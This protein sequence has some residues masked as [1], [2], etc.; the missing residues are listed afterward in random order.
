EMV[1]LIRRSQNLYDPV[2]PPERKEGQFVNYAMQKVNQFNRK[3]ADEEY[4]L[5]MVPMDVRPVPRRKITPTDLYDL[6]QNSIAELQQMKYRLGLERTF[7]MPEPE[8]GRTIDDVVYNIELALRLL[9]DF[10]RQKRIQFDQQGLKKR[11]EQV[12]A[13]VNHIIQELVH[14]QRRKG[15]PP[16]AHQQ[17]VRTVERLEPRHTYYRSIEVLRQISRVRQQH[18]LGELT[19]PD[20]PN[21]TITP[22]EVYEM[23]LRIDRELEL[24]YQRGGA[25]LNDFGISHAENLNPDFSTPRT[26]SDVYQH[27]GQVA[28]RLTQLAGGEAESDIVQSNHRVRQLLAELLL[29]AD[30]RGVVVDPV[31]C[32][33]EGE[34]VA[35]LRPLI[36]AELRKVGQQLHRLKQRT[37][38]LTEEQHHYP[39]LDKPE[40]SWVSGELGLLLV[41]S[42]HLKQYLGISQSVESRALRKLHIEGGMKLQVYRGLQKISGVLQQLLGT[43]EESRES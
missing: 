7:S 22:S 41:N 42:W 43:S 19:V 31:C 36:V 23:A 18:G 40:L 12:Y 8:P 5:W 4:N 26:P 29:I 21:R 17:N 20:F 30:A 6:L 10:Q 37:G 35:P 25:D 27:W 11:P 34:A 38:L 9:P 16:P 33:E 1:W 15:V 3:L 24:I 14:Y 32:A 13:V 39:N 28:H 2:E